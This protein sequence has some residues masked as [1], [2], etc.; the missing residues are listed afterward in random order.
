VAVLDTTCTNDGGE[1]TDFAALQDLLQQ[2]DRGYWREQAACRDRETAFFFPPPGSPTEPI[3]RFCAQCPVR[4]ACLS[5]AV[6]SPQPEDGWWGGRPP[7]EVEELRQ[8]LRSVHSAP[9]PSAKTRAVEILAA[10]GTIAEAAAACAISTR[11]V[12]R[13][14]IEHR[15]VLQ[16]AG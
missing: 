2:P 13:Y 15:P 8:A 10:G 6:E 14:L 5:A 3:R 12:R 7:K 4:L 11:T 9:Q 1:L 16:E